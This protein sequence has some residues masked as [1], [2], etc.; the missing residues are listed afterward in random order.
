MSFPT[1]ARLANVG[2]LSGL[3]AKVVGTKVSALPYFAFWEQQHVRP[4]HP[5]LPCAVN[6]AADRHLF[7]PR[8]MGENIARAR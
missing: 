6:V 7:T 3:R 4:I 2:A 8:Q 5:V 1:P